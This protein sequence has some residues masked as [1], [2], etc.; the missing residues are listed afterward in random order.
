V[1]EV[2]VVVQQA[3]VPDTVVDLVQVQA[4]VRRAAGI[5]KVIPGMLALVE[6]A[7]AMVV[8]KE[9]APLD[10]VATGVVLEL[11]LE[12]VR[13]LAASPR[14]THHMQMQMPLLTVVERVVV[15]MVGMAMA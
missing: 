14:R 7:E 3:M 2:E 9:A 15:K 11:D 5:I 13:E 10:P 8:G 1:V 4:L 6:V 12:L